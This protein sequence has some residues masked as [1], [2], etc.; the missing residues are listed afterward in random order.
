MAINYESIIE[1]MRLKKKVRLWQLIAVVIGTFLLLVIAGNKSGTG[2]FGSY[3]ARVTVTG[4]IEEDRERTKILEDLAE[5]NSV[6]AVILSIDS[7]GGTLVGGETLYNEI[8]NI[9]EKKPVVAVMGTLATSAAYMIACA[10]DRIFAHKGTLTGSIGV[11]LQT[12]EVTE[13]A[14]KIGVKVKILK[15]GNLKGGPS[16]LEKMTPEMVTA[17]QSVLD[18]SQAFFA[19]LVKKSRKFSD[20]EMAELS[21]GGVFTGLQALD[22]KLVDQ[23]GGEKEAV[24]WLEENKKIKK[25]LEIRDVK[26]YR[27]KDKIEDFIYGMVGKVDILPK[28]FF[29]QGLLAIWQN[30][31]K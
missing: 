20:S 2:G 29:L 30:G 9:A 8:R 31:I 4:I 6:K 21:D 11:L 23:L 16:L 5:D 14:E 3:I 12:A 24:K 28:T 10:T 27:E 26:L 19:S 18:S 1:R 7:P 15:S 22:K 17:M 13:L 25:N